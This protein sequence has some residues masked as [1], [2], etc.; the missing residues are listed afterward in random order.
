MAFVKQVRLH[1]AR[2]MLTRT[3]I[4]TSVSEA[5]FS[6]GFANL[7]NFARD[8]FKQ[9]GERP[10]DTLKRAKG[11]LPPLGGI[12]AQPQRQIKHKLVSS[13]FRISLDPH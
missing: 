12:P 13:I 2:Q 11:D 4:D 10:S 6:C 3:K 1:R 8:Y 9:F 7:G 5:A